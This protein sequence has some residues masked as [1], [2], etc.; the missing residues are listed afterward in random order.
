VA[1]QPDGQFD[2]LLAECAGRSVAEF[3]DQF[4]FSQLQR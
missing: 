4:T 1:Q 2:E 3:S